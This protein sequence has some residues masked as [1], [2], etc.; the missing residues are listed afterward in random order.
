MK[1]SEGRKEYLYDEYSEPYHFNNLIDMMNEVRT[2]CQT[3]S[4][5]KFLGRPI[6][7]GTSRQI[8]HTADPDE[9][10]FLKLIKGIRYTYAADCFHF[11]TGNRLFIGNH[12]QCF[13]Q[14]Q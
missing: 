5:Q 10:F 6:Q 14:C 4:H 8:R 11:S 2:L 3:E 12:S 9:A 1:L 13:Q 7:F